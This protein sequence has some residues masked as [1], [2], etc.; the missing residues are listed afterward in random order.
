[1]K[2]SCYHQIDAC[3]CGKATLDICIEY[4]SVVQRTNFKKK[5]CTTNYTRSS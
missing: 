5:L 1:M 2:Y 3:A 4:T